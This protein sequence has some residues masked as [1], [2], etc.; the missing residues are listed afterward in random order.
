M[1]PSMNL[2]IEWSPADLVPQVA[3]LCDVRNSKTSAH[4]R[5]VAK[6]LLALGNGIGGTLRIKFE[7]TTKYASQNRYAEELQKQL[8][9]ELALTWP[10]A[11]TSA[12]RAWFSVEAAPL[13][14][15]LFVPPF[16]FDS[17]PRYFHTAWKRYQREKRLMTVD[18]MRAWKPSRSGFVASSPLIADLRNAFESHMIEFKRE[19]SMSVKCDI[20]K[21]ICGFRNGDGGYLCIGVEETKVEGQV[22][23][24]GIPRETVAE[25]ITMV[26]QDALLLEP[27]VS[28]DDI[29]S[30]QEEVNHG[31]V[32]L[33]ICVKP[34][35]NCTQVTRPETKKLDIVTGALVPCAEQQAVV[36]LDNDTLLQETLSAYFNNGHEGNAVNIITGQVHALFGPGWFVPQTFF[37]PS[38]PM[39]GLRDPL[40]LV[41]SFGLICGSI[42]DARLTASHLWQHCFVR[43]GVGRVQ[44][45]HDV[46]E[47]MRAF[48]P[49][50]N[51]CYVDDLRAM[52][53]GIIRLGL[54]FG[55]HRGDESCLS[56]LTLEQAKLLRI[57]RE[58]LL[59]N[60]AVLVGPP[61]SGKTVAAV[62]L[63][64]E[65]LEQENQ[66]V[67]Y[68]CANQPLANHVQ[69]ALGQVRITVRVASDE[70]PTSRDFEKHNVFMFDEL[71]SYPNSRC[72]DFFMGE[73]RREVWALVDPAQAVSRVSSGL[74]TMTVLGNGYPCH[75]F[76]QVVRNGG[77]IFSAVKSWAQ[78]SG[79]TE[80]NKKWLKTWK[81][82]PKNI[83]KGDVIYLCGSIDDAMKMLLDDGAREADIIVLVQRVDDIEAVRQEVPTNVMVESAHR[84]KGLDSPFVI[85]V[86]PD[87]EPQHLST[88][89]TGISRAM[90]ICVVIADSEQKL[91]LLKKCQLVASGETRLHEEMDNFVA[92]DDSW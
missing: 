7:T 36:L 88:L 4:V 48:Q 49:L 69:R 2:G 59:G 80:A 42:E 87:P 33:V 34:G 12:S 46:G 61:G 54:L 45:A 56:L 72:W 82:H 73:Q 67:L 76:S 8:E 52:K 71:Q 31:K 18:E 16:P 57:H 13:D 28:E 26:R 75:N 70:S 20:M 65:C 84:F 39:R 32:V 62:E 22:N 43:I 90:L 25:I 41:P 19:A 17:R 53:L 24:P 79:T 68:V 86:A 47:V 37:R 3:I 77:K 1:A 55:L 58:N 23:M 5:D 92:E 35:R 74:P 78:K 50:P 44:S 27:A 64:K 14:L 6:V 29:V 38:S 11:T 60:K 30:I 63:V 81:Q 21:Y 51:M 83:V 9:N 85:F 66:V 91:E 15:V 89:V 40:L 10:T